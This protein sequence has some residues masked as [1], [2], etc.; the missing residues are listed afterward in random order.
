[1]IKSYTNKA[2]AEEDY[3]GVTIVGLDETS[4]RKGH[5]YVL[6]R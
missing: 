1:M 6:F 3:S 5:D 4:V 2:R